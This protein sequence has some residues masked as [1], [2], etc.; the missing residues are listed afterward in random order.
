MMHFV[1]N[2]CHFDLTFQQWRSAVS[3]SASCI[4]LRLA[5]FCCKPWRLG[6][7]FFAIAEALVF[8]TIPGVS[9]APF[10]LTEDVYLLAEGIDPHR[11]AST[12]PPPTVDPVNVTEEAY[13]LCGSYTPPGSTMSE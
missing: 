9:P 10:L 3:A 12:R 13:V 11:A 2:I 6:C 7:G 8:V 4:P 1:S 5:C